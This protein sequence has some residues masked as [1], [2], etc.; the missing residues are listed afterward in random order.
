MKKQ[1]NTTGFL[2]GVANKQ[3]TRNG[4]NSYVDSS[5]GMSSQKS[6]SVLLLFYM[7]VKL[8]NDHQYIFLH[9]KKFYVAG[10]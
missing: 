2:I 8:K 10:T 3:F 9:S 5:E 7:M 6:S 4:M 1:Y